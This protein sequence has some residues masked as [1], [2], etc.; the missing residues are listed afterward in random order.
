MNPSSLKYFC[1]LYDKLRQKNQKVSG[2]TVWG[3][4]EQGGWGTRSAAFSS[5]WSEATAVLI[6]ILL[7]LLQHYRC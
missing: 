6:A 2:L 5:S 1:S 4:P 7:Y 3:K